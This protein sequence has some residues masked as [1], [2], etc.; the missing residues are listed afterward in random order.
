MLRGL[1]ITHTVTFL[2]FCSP[3]SSTI[4]S[5]CEYSVLRLSKTGRTVG[6]TDSRLDGWSVG[7]TDKSKYR[8]LCI[9]T[10]MFFL[11]KDHFLWV[12]NFERFP[13]L[14]KLARGWPWP[15]QKTWAP[16]CLENSGHG[17]L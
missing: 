8:I 17:A 4:L 10:G 13:D 3:Q 1:L 16:S 7:R 5:H 6:G 14:E 2:C 12:R 15:V 9:L 11:V